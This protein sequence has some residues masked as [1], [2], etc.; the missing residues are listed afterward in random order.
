MQIQ[1]SISEEL[2]PPGHLLHPGETYTIPIIFEIPEHVSP[3]ACSHR[4]TVVRERHLYLPPSI[5]SWEKNDISGGSIYVDYTVCARLVLG[6]DSHG[7]NKSVDHS[8]SLKV[9]PILPEQPPINI[10]P[11]NSQYCLSQT[12]TVRK[13]LLGAKAGIF[14][15]STTQP[16]PISLQ[17]DHLQTSESELVIKLHYTTSSPSDIPPEVHIKRAAIETVTSFWLGP[18][19]HLPDHDQVIS[20]AASTVAPWS[21]SHPLL[22][23][24]VDKMN[25]ERDSNINPSTESERRAS[26]PFRVVQDGVGT[27][28]PAYKAPRATSE[29][30]NQS[31]PT[32]YETTIIQ[33]FRLPSEKLLFIPTFHSCMVSRMYR[34]RITLVTSAHGTALSLIV[35]LQIT[36]EGFTGVHDARTLV[37][38][39]TDSEPSIDS[40]PPYSK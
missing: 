36:S 21:A 14:R 1:M 18:I 4:N 37:Y 34:I 7:K 19:G 29:K 20:G 39:N 32:T 2:M 3:S 13:N 35:P 40:P 9:I 23:Q 28:T 15:I 38:C 8:I 16:K 10:T 33:P 31:E 22:L 5:G 26:E 11:S 12:K 25:W 27:Q 6:K 30:F 17:M 24:G